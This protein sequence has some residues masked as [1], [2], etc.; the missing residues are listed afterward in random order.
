MCIASVTLFVILTPYL[1]VSFQYFVFNLDIILFLFFSVYYTHKENSGST[2][3]WFSTSHSAITV[4]IASFTSLIY[5]HVVF[6]SLYS[7]RTY[8]PFVVFLAILECFPVKPFYFVTALPYL[9]W[10]KISPMTKVWCPS[11]YIWE[12]TFSTMTLAK[13]LSVFPYS[14]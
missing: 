10:S 1:W 6:S 14:N 2:T 3:I 4:W 5:N 7:I 8:H 12:L 13:Y 9:W 11:L